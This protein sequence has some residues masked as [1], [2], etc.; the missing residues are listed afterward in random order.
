MKHSLRSRRYVGH[1][2]DATRQ[3]LIKCYV[4]KHLDSSNISK[5]NVIANHT[6][7]LSK[8]ILGDGEDKVILMLDDTCIY[9]QKSAHNIL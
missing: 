9:V 8:T 6:R 1:V 5:E 3:A 7:P 2:L 4:R